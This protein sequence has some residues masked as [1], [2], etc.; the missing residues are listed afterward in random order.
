MITFKTLILSSSLALTAAVCPAQNPAGSAAPVSTG[1]HIEEIPLQ[2]KVAVK[3]NLLYD[4]F[5]NVNLGIEFVVDPKWS[6]DISADYNNWKFS[7]GRR[8]KHWMVQPEAR[9]WWQGHPLKGHFLPFH[10]VGGQYNVAF[11]SPR[12]QGWG[13]G[14][15]VGYGYAWQFGSHWGLEAE[16]AV[17]Y[18][19]LHYD[20]YP[21]TECGHK[22]GTVNK[23]YFGPTKAALNLVYR[24]GKDK[25]LIAVAD[26]PLPVVPPTPVV[27]EPVVEP[28]PSVLHFALVEAP[29]SGTRTSTHSGRAF[30]NYKVNSTVLE[31]SRGTNA[32]E[33]ASI[34]G[35]LDSVLSNPSYKVTSI[36]LKGY[37]SPEGGFEHN[38]WLSKGR[39]EALGNYLVQNVPGISLSNLDVELGDEDWKGLADYVRDSSLPEKA[40]ILAICTDTS[41]SPDAREARLRKEFPS[42]YAILKEKAYPSLRRCDYTIEYTRTYSVEERN[43]LKE[44]NEAL[45]AL[46]LDRAGALL[47]GAPDTPETAYA[48]GVLAAQLGDYNAAQRYF[49]QA[50][51]AGL[52]EANAALSTL[53]TLMQK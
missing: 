2:Q 14:A 18:A 52:P 7:H 48:R 36:R 34:T 46:D 51:Q 43:Y 19:R 20:T 53:A 30:V 12:R 33:L 38:Q 28:E 11:S 35:P 26:E 22:T 17:G 40:R 29:E 21:C 44:V 4:A 6:I 42:Q 50:L 15:G 23:N 9:W 8:W 27:E 10:L 49:I 5:M 16:V 32:R 41:L 1:A 39:A 24:F 45:R 37:A 25:E 47:Q 13:I 3:T 31:P